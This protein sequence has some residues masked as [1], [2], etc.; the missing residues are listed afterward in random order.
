M[1]RFAVPRRRTMTLTTLTLA[2]LVVLLAV[3]TVLTSLDVSR[4]SKRANRD[5]ALGV[6]YQDIRAAVAD[7]GVAGISYR[8]QPARSRRQLTKAQARLREGVVQLRRDGAPSDRAIAPYLVADELRYQWGAR[9]HFAAVDRGDDRTARRILR[10]EM[11]PAYRNV[12]RLVD[13]AAFVHRKQALDA[14]SGVSHRSATFAG[15]ATLAYAGGFLLLAACGYF[16]LRLQTSLRQMASGQHQ[17]ARQ[18]PLT[19]L[20]NR[21]LWQELAEARLHAKAPV[22][23][24]VLDLDGFKHVNDTLGHDQGDVLLKVVAERLSGALRTDDVVA[25]MGGDEFALLLPGTDYAG[26][27]AVADAVALALE[28]P[29]HLRGLE[30][31]LRASAGIALAPA[32]GTD[33]DTL[34]K[35]ADR[36]MYVAKATGA[37]AVVFTDDLRLG[38]SAEDELLE[39][40]ERA[41]AEDQLLLH[42]QPIVATATGETVAVE[43]LVRWEH[44]VHGTLGPDAFIPL[45]ERSGLVVPLGRWVLRTACAQ[46][47]TWPT[48]GRGAPPVVSV[49]LSAR[50][51]LEPALL[52]DVRE[53]LEAASL[54][55]SRLML[56]ITETS[57]MEDPEAAARRLMELRA[58]GVGLAVDDFGTGHSSLAYLRELPFTDLKLA[59]PFVRD[60]GISPA[61]VD[62]ARGIVALAHT[63]KLRVIAEGVEVV[64]QLERLEEMEC[65]LV[66]GYLFARPLPVEAL[67]EHLAR[68]QWA[69]R[70]QRAQGALA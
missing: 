25:R 67:A 56:E 43:A 61:D 54:A 27:R 68:A 17:L 23:V 11:L 4:S 14:T 2:L 53:T 15:W 19:G 60:L 9:Q 13:L 7:E 30:L 44:P 33:V 6:V 64:D 41:I 58:L 46:A 1:S 16:L 70:A 40:L 49:N 24:L 28:P 38:V 63:L 36:A 50:E 37:G 69:Q 18:D 20:P 48:Q 32:H 22:A 8:D 34:L 55:P 3:G 39:E 35:H 42:Y 51:L 26:A 65:D 62:L 10:A 12:Q 52:T 66:Q 5:V 29:C 47:S 57:V 45:A 59:R 31:R 21:R